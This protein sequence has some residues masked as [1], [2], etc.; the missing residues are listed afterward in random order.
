[1]LSATGGISGGRSGGRSALSG[2]ASH[3]RLASSLA[4]QY[5]RQLLRDL[6]LSRLSS[7][8]AFEESSRPGTPGTLGGPTIRM[9]AWPQLALHESERLV[10]N[11]E[12]SWSHNV[13][14]A[15]SPGTS[16]AAHS[17]SSTSIRRGR[18][19]GGR[20]GLSTSA[21]SGAL[22]ASSS[23]S[24]M[25]RGAAGPRVLH[26]SLNAALLG[27]EVEVLPALLDQTDV[28]MREEAL[29]LRPMASYCSPRHQRTGGFAKSL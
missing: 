10:R 9:G 18:S 6:S 5:K 13:W 11:L 16:G 22:L 26:A 20:G 15:S 7:V 8:R 19:R 27:R 17:S 1:M 24:R 29:A 12:G 3:G 2:S 28:D 25:L 4:D 14:P 21:S 23:S